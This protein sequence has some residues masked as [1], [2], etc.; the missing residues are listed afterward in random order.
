MQQTGYTQIGIIG[1]GA[2]GTAIGHALTR[3]Q[4]QVLYYD[5]DPAR[6]TTAS[7]EDLISTCEV[8]LLCVPSWEVEEVVKAIHKEAHPSKS[9][10]VIATSK[11]VTKGF[12]TM[13]R[14][15]ADNLP[16]HYAVGV[17]GGAMI[18]E[19]IEQQRPANGVLGLTD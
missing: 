4:T 19:E 9:V 13:D 2:S 7:I 1:A 11:G 16:K 3:A 15:L 6:T 8:L 17:L 18:A 14:L 5:K 10:L 12:V